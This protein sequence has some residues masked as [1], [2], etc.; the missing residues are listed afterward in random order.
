MLERTRFINDL[1]KNNG[2]DSY[3]EIGYGSGVNFKDIKCKRKVSV[4]PFENYADYV[5]TSD[6]FF[7]A[8]KKKF[9]IIFVDGLHLCEQVLKDV[10]NSFKVLKPNGKIVIHDCYPEKEE[11]QNRI[12]T[13]SN[14]QGDVWK[15]IVQLA[16]DGYCMRLYDIETGIVVIPDGQVIQAV[17]DGELDWGWY[18]KHYKRMLCE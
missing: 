18:I 1:I 3:L 16:K 2:Y 15:A 17:P 6:D 11:R 14:W 5:C 7:K 13:T 9:D 4:D 10:K 8:N 12:R